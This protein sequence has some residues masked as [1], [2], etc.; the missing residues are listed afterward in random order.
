M[1]LRVSVEEEMLVLGRADGAV[2]A[3]SGTQVLKRCTAP[4]ASRRT[5]PS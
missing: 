2:V 5:S 4:T 3:Q 1:T